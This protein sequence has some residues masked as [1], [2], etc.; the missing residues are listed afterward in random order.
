VAHVARCVCWS[1]W[2]LNVY[3]TAAMSKRAEA[4]EEGLTTLHVAAHNG[5]LDC[6]ELLIAKGVAAINHNYAP[7]ARRPARPLARHVSTIHRVSQQDIPSTRW[8]I[9]AGLSHARHGT[10]LATACAFGS[11]L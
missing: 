8:I 9:G 10:A 6:L 7:P 11:W 1:T 2:P 4:R 3:A 5:A